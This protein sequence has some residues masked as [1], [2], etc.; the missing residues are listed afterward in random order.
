MENQDTIDSKFRYAI[1]VAKRAKQLVKGAKPKIDFKT[2]NPLTL[3]IEEINQGKINFHLIEKGDQDVLSADDIF[4][5]SDESETP[6]EQEA[7][8]VAEPEATE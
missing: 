8:A 7:E 4:G 1:L 3:A 6:E 5:D 2:E